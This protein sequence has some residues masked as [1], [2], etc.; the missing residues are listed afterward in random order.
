MSCKF[1]GTVYAFLTPETYESA[2]NVNL[3]LVSSYVAL[4]VN[5]IICE[6]RIFQRFLGQTLFCLKQNSSVTN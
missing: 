6:T 1:E 2:A 4:N 5:H 3:E